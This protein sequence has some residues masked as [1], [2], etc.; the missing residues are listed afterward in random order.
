PEATRERV[1]S[2]AEKLG[3]SP[4]AAAQRLVGGRSFLL[5]FHTFEEIFPADQTDFYFD[6]LLGVERE[7][8]RRGY[9]LMLLS[10]T[11][12]SQNTRGA[13]GSNATAR[14]L[15]VADG[16]ILVGRHVD[17]ALLAELDAN[18]HPFV[19]IGRREIAGIEVPYV[20]FDY[21]SATA[22]IVERLATA[23]HRNI[24]YIG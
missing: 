21:A 17:N 12:A 14:R 22:R 4:N 7:A 18:G 3:Y 15:L 9:D 23:G 1:I 20:A 24:G 19:L 6:F 11:A 8:S 16:G 10:P 2:A 5:G 13:F